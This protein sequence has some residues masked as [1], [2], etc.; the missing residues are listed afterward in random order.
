MHTDPHLVAGFSDPSGL[1]PPI[2]ANGTRDFRRLTGLL[3]QPMAALAG[4]GYPQPVWHCSVRAAP[5]DRMLSDGEWAQ[6]AARV[7]D[8]IGLAPA[9][10]DLGVRWVAVRHAPDHIHVVATL[11]RQDGDRPATWNDFYRVPGRM[12]GRGT[13]VRA[14]EHRSGG[15]H[16]RP[17]RHPGRDGAG[18]PARMGRGAPRHT[19]P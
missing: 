10:D 12:P 19:P 16:R 6:V 2:R 15:S 18:D 3:A 5:E 11:A 7:M 13:P 4:P 1:E 9:G 17:A 8:R 14:T